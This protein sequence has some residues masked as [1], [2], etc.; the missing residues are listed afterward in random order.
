MNFTFFLYHYSDM[1]MVTAAGIAVG[2]A[3]GFSA[4]RWR[5]K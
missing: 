5:T 4:A 3:I 1:V 2:I